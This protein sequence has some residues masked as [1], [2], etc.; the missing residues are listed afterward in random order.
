MAYLVMFVLAMAMV[1]L[2][3]PFG[4]ALSSDSLSYLLMARNIAN[5]FGIALPSYDLNFQA[6][7]PATMW[8]PLYPSILAV[9]IYVSGGD[10][11]KIVAMVPFVNAVLLFLLLVLVYRF[12]SDFCCV[13]K[14]AIWG[15]ILLYVF[16]PSQILIGM[17][18]WSENIF[19][20][21]VFA[22]YYV[23]IYFV[24]SENK[25]TSR[26]PLLYSTI[27][28]ASATYVRYVGIFFFI[29]LCFTIILLTARGLRERLINVI[30]ASAL[31]LILTAPL[32][33]RNYFISTYVSGADRVHPQYQIISDFWQLL[34]L[35]REDVFWMP[36]PIMM[37]VIAAILLSSVSLIKN[38]QSRFLSTN[39]RILAVTLLWVVTYMTAW[40]AARKVQSIDLD[41][42]M[43]SVI[44]I[45]II[46]LPFIL[47]GSH[48]SRLWRWVFGASAYVWLVFQL[49]HGVETLLEI[50]TSWNTQQVPG[51]I[52]LF[53]YNSITDP[54]LDAFRFIN[55]T[56]QPSLGD[57]IITDYPK[58]NIVAYFMS[59]SRVVRLPSESELTSNIESFRSHYRIIFILSD[60]SHWEFVRKSFGDQG[61]ELL[62]QINLTPMWYVAKIPKSEA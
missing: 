11:A 18:L 29:A 43:L 48:S 62:Y 9:L 5:G 38:R 45:F 53:Y 20:P 50:R 52:G 35:L 60:L 36:A 33:L 31:Y 46:L 23:L 22:A 13:H 10:F 34:M 6:T 47:Y 55:D 28:L 39:S 1:T 42:R 16:L 51:Q 49:Y 44:S 3:T 24:V 14:A 7:V 32:F 57:L 30:S 15:L 25:E 2:T 27:F 58:L 56:C 37:L 8:P 59:G 19:I 12:A 41:S 54:R 26:M 21:L 40:L 17:Y 61:L 4:A